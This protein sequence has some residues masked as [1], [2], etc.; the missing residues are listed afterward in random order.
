MY[1]CVQYTNPIAMTQQVARWKTNLFYFSFPK[2]RTLSLFHSRLGSPSTEDSAIG[3]S[4]WLQYIFECRSGE[5]TRPH[6]RWTR[7]ELTKR[8]HGCQNE[9]KSIKQI[10]GTTSELFSAVVCICWLLL[11]SSPDYRHARSP[12][13]RPNLHEIVNIGEMTNTFYI[14]RTS[15]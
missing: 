12:S 14:P 11:P 10:G 4:M 13:G 7:L 6:T 2:T 15:T 1:I 9:N 5:S 3:L 8:S